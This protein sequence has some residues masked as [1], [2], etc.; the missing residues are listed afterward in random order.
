MDCPHREVKENTVDPSAGGRW[1]D[2]YSRNK[3]KMDSVFCL[4]CFGL[5][6]LF[7]QLISKDVLKTK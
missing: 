3:L 1:S 6:L 4:T 2:I 5:A 7:A